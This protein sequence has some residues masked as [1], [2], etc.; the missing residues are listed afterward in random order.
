MSNSKARGG[1]WLTVAS[2]ALLGLFAWSEAPKLLGVAEAGWDLL[3]QRPEW[4]V[5]GEPPP[6]GDTS[7]ARFGAQY[8]V[9]IHSIGGC[10][11]GRRE[12]D[13]ASSYNVLVGL[14]KRIPVRHRDEFWFLTVPAWCAGLFGL[15]LVIRARRQRRAVAGATT[16]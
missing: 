10:V 7:E 2:L 11:V 5:Y 4:K 1:R 16:P 15:R 6:V 8:G 14:A 9:R 3:W 13:Y 12:R